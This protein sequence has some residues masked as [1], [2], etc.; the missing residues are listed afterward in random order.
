[1]TMQS[2]TKEKVILLGSGGHAKVVVDILEKSETYEIV[3]IITKDKINSFLNYPV[4]GNDDLLP[5]LYKKGIT[6]VAMG[7]GSFR[8]NNLRKK[9]FSK[10]KRMGFNVVSA[11][12]PTATISKSV[13]LGEGSVIF[14]GA[15]INT[16]VVIGDNVIIATGSTIDHETR[17]ENHVLISAGVT[18][19]ANNLIGEGALLALGSKVISGLKIGKNVVVGAG[20][21]VTKD[22]KKP[23]IYIGI[24]ARKK[25]A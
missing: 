1:M 21:V 3:G 20:A 22:I 4:L 13:I 11:I 2:T 25:G 15:I 7:I 16:L 17:I 8:D 14:A 24:P 23:G 5:I 10:V 12:D 19:G 6:K 18:I 9:V